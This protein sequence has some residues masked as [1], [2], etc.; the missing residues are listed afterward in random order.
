[1][2]GVKASQLTMFH[3]ILNFLMLQEEMQSEA[4]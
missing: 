4:E 2:G 1:M 3:R